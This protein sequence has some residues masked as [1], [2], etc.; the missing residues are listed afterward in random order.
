MNISKAE[1]LFTSILILTGSA[2]FLGLTQKPSLGVED[3][4]DW[5]NVN[6][7]NISV[8]SKAW[9]NNPSKLTVNYTDVELQYRVLMNGVILVEGQRN[10]IQI[11]KGN[12]T[13]KVNSTL[14]QDR[15]P[16]WWASHVRNN[17]TSQIQIPL[18]V[19]A[20][21]GPATI[22]FHAVVYQDRIDTDLIGVINQAVNRTEGTYSY[23]EVAG[24][25]TGPEIEIVEGS[26]EW[27]RTSTETTNLQLDLEVR[28]PNSYPL[29]VPG[30]AG[31]VEM[32]GVDM[33]AWSNE[34]ARLIQSPDDDIIAPGETEEITFQIEMDNSK[35]DDWLT[36]HIRKDERTQGSLNMKLLFEIQD[37]Q[38]TLPP[39]EGLQ[40]GFRFQT[41]IL[42]DQNST[43][44]FDECQ[45]DQGLENRLD[46]SFSSETGSE[47]LVNETVG[48]IIG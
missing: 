29:P 37:Q 11:K 9:I 19:K 8:T 33:L 30:T 48:G 21:I 23:G 42:E 40:C 26:A 6:S 15:I 41:N 16:Y 24:Y 18:T 28:N 47:G 32:N 10:Q 39:G 14:I 46:S 35:V 12:Q 45:L 3:R 36:S 1:V 22:P 7:E 13:K 43:S 27:G 38:L 4:G 31:N 34:E 25:S 17:E 44:S 2:V 20:G 5:Q